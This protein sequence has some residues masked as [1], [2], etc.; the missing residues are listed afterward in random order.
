VRRI[1]S[2]ITF[3]VLLAGLAC[4]SFVS[5][6]GVKAQAAESLNSLR[7]RAEKGDA[8]AQFSLALRYDGGRGVLQD[9]A[10]AAR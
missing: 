8:E 5:G 9:Y 7:G 3:A 4:I 6:Q 2:L 10:E 1:Q